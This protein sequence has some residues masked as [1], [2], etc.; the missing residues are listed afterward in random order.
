MYLPGMHSTLFLQSQ[1]RAFLVANTEGHMG[2]LE[3]AGSSPHSTPYPH[4]GA[5]RGCLPGSRSKVGALKQALLPP[6]SL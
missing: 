3:A 2:A 4:C 5:S 1:A 6:H